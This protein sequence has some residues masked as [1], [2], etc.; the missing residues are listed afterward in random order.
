M[1]HAFAIGFAG[2][3]LAAAATTAAG[4]D[5]G[6][7]R[8]PMRNGVVTDGPALSDAWAK[9]GPAKLWQSEPV[10]G[11]QNGGYGCPVVAGGRVFV[12]SNWKY[13]VP[14]A[15]RTL[16]AGGLQ[17][18]GWLGPRLPAE[19]EKKVEA[20]RVCEERAKLVGKPLN[21]W[22]AKWVE[23]NTKDVADEK[24]RKQHARI[25]SDRI[26]RGAKALPLDELEK[27]AGIKD[28]QF[29]SQADL[30]AWYAENRISVA[31][32]AEATKAI[33]VDVEK[34]WD[35]LFCL[36]ADTGK[37]L[38]MT[39]TDGSP[40]GWSASTTPTVAGNRC[41]YV[42]SEGRV[43]CLNVEDGKASWTADLKGGLVHSS[44]LVAE[45]KVVV[46]GGRLTALD[47]ATGQVVWKQAKVGGTDNSPVAWKHG[48][49]VYVLCNTGRGVVCVRLSDG[50]LLWTVPG[51]GQSSVAVDGDVM[52]VLGAAKEVGL[53]AYRLAPEK[54]EK[55]WS[56]PEVQDPAASPV[57]HDGHVYAIAH[58]GAAC[59]ELTSGQVKWNT[60]AGANAESSPVVVDGKL[61]AV[62][63]KALALVRATPEKF[64]LP[65][66]AALPVSEYS[67][68]AV[69]DGRLYVRL[70]EAIVCLDLTGT[71]GEPA[72]PEKPQ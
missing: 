32:K 54:A 11:H 19:L 22:I 58:T 28:R 34:A 48:D 15:T 71:P 53:V 66:K 27:L 43:A 44:P 72:D 17:R 67:S 55:M 5:F 49:A 29:P 45:G 46:L 8:G 25:A 6:Q 23:E 4:G 26:A 40:T 56:V 24:T 51:G 18:L 64:D 2:L 41:Y 21:E 69:S 30:D 7:W 37:R 52:V 42:G 57:I 36:A 50:E 59:V 60:K 20:A 47:A 31:V 61:L 1:R 12:Y 63:T 39:E 70:K 68:P 16:N 62:M 33:P 14:I 13:R 10:M 35:R 9:T 65:A 38:W 3:V